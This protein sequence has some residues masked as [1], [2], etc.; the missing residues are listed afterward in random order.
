MMYNYNRKMCKMC[1]RI[2]AGPPAR[3]S[4]AT[5]DSR[6][7]TPR[8][9]CVERKAAPSGPTGDSRHAT[10]GIRQMYVVDRLVNAIVSCP[11]ARCSGA[12][13][14]PYIASIHNIFLCACSPAHRAQCASV[15]LVWLLVPL[16]ALGSA[17][18]GMSC[19]TTCHAPIESRQME[20]VSQSCATCGGPPPAF[21]MAIR[22]QKT[23]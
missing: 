3:V 1:V 20:S 18:D 9:A 2:P 21:G 11:G 12:R 13:E 4:R 17:D 6:H 22:T 14:C 15:P 10:V 8:R 23:P 7:T 5:A 16:P 19:M